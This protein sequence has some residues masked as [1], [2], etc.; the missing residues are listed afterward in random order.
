[1]ANVFSLINLTIENI[2]ELWPLSLRIPLSELITHRKNSFFSTSLLLITACSTNTSIKTVFFY[3]IQQ[4]HRL[5][6][7]T[8]GIFTFRLYHFPLINTVLHITHDE[9]FPQVFHQPISERYGFRKIMTCINMHQ[10]ER[11]FPR[12]E[13][14]FGEMYQCNAVLTS[15]KQQSRIFKL[16]CYFSEYVNRFRLQ[17]I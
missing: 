16:P 7:I 8:T 1:H 12:S 5:Q 2:P 4:C 6:R 14:F 13:G 17:M 3:G 11:K 10:R 9:L 15:G